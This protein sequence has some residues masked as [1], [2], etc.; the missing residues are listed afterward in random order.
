MVKT[1]RLSIIPNNYST[2]STLSTHSPS[3]LL[4][5]HYPIYFLFQYYRLSIVDNIIIINTLAKGLYNQPA[6]QISPA[7]PRKYHII[8]KP[9]YLKNHRFTQ[10]ITSTN[11]LFSIKCHI[12]CLDIG[13]AIFLSSTQN[14]T[15]KIRCTSR[16]QTLTVL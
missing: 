9:P 12:S 14:K 15:A 13:S 11:V 5:Q 8:D 1:W 4:S 16:T 2:L 3:P 7:P 6:P 10:T